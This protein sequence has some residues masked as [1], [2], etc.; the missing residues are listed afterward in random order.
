MLALAYVV[1]LLPDELSGLSG[2]CLVL[3]F[4]AL[5]PSDRFA[6]RH[7]LAPVKDTGTIRA[8]ASRITRDGYC[9]RSLP[10]A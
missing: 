1:N 7:D 8:A 3:G 9:G 6:F 5:S 2:G 10:V 4:V